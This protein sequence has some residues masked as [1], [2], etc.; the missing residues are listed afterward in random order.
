[1]FSTR[2]QALDG[3]AIAFTMIGQYKGFSLVE[4]ETEEQ[5]QNAVAFYTPLITFTFVPIRQARVAQQL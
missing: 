2:A 1:L 4:V 5:M 3:T